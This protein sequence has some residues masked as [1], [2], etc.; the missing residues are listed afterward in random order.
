MA[1][2]SAADAAAT[3]RRIL[4]I[5]SAQF[6]ERDSL[7]ERCPICDE[8]RQYVR[9]DGQAWTTTDELRKTHRLKIA[10]EAENI[11]GIGAEPEFV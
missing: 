2:A 11:A 1:R 10:D 3:A 7:P 4:D 5:A 9:W 6:A 8:E